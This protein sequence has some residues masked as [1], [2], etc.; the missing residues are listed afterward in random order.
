MEKT[1]SIPLRIIQKALTSDF[2]R[3][4]SHKK[5]K[6]HRVDNYTEK[7]QYGQENR[8][9]GRPVEEERIFELIKSIHAE[10]NQ[11]SLDHSG[12]K[13]SYSRVLLEKFFDK[14]KYFILTLKKLKQHE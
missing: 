14:K 9:F 11:V 7:N 5:V 4:K 2:G 13:K 12:N 6:A 3:K 10:A 8:N 1:A